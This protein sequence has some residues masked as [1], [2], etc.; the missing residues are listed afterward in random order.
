M[1]SSHHRLLSPVAHDH[2]TRKR[3][4]R[5]QS[6]IYHTSRFVKLY[7]LLPKINTACIRALLL[8]IT[9]DVFTRNRAV[10]LLSSGRKLPGWNFGYGL[11]V[12]VVFELNA[13]KLLKIMPLLL[14]SSFLPIRR[15]QFNMDATWTYHLMRSSK[16]NNAGKTWTAE[17]IDPLFS[18]LSFLKISGWR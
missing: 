17:F 16:I 9:R 10:M 2:S 4:H 5:T 8:L 6:H 13:R 15:S 14:P 11:R 1:W 18:I 3:A 7:S 12:Y